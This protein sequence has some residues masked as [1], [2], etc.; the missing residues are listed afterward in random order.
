MFIDHISVYSDDP[1]KT[2]EF[3]ETY[4][5]GESNQGIK[6]EESDTIAYWL[7][8]GGGGTAKLEIIERP[9]EEKMGENNLDYLR[10]AFMQDSK[11]EV[12][13]KIKELEE[14]G[15]QVL[16]EPAETE[17]G[18]YSGLILDPDDNQIELIYGRPGGLHCPT[19]KQRKR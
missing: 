8:F 18:Y 13:N 6:N 17:D 10:M 12:D 11:E 1:R 4:F 16:K 9:E 15:Y 5:G 2:K 3:Y 19:Y 7:S 14:A